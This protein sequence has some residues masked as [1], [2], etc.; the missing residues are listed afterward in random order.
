MSEIVDKFIAD[1]DSEI[2]AGRLR[3]LLWFCQYPTH[4][5]VSWHRL[6]DGRAIPQC[7]TCQRWG[8]AR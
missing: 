1:V 2:N 5:G 7:E 3:I 6:D 4:R 8:P